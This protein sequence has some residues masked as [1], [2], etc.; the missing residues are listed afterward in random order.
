VNWTL[1]DAFVDCLDD[2]FRR[3]RSDGYNMWARVCAAHL[4]IFGEELQL[5]TEDG[6]FL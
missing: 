2:H 6:R 4:R 5:K 1:T 3:W